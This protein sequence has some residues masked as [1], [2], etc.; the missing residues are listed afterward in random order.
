MTMEVNEMFTYVKLKNFMSFKEVYFNF[1]NGKR[2]PKKFVSIYGE[3][4]SGKSNFVQ[5]IDF[6]IKST[7]SFGMMGESGELREMMSL[8]K[9]PEQLIKLLMERMS[10]Q[11]MA[12]LCRMAE[13]ED[14]AC[15]EYG[16]SFNG[17]EGYYTIHFADRF[18]YER[19][20]YFTGKQRGII[21]EIVLKDGKISY[22]FSK[23]LFGNKKVEMEMIDEITKYWGKHTFLSILRKERKEKNEQ[24]MEENYLSY[25]F[26][27]LDM[28][29]EIT[30]HHKKNSLGGVE[31]AAKKPVNILQNLETGRVERSR[32]YI[33]DCSE[34]IIREFFT[35]TYADIKDVYYEKKYEE[36]EVTYKLF[37]KKMIGGKIR[38][39]D[40]LHESAGTQQIL[41]IIR[42]LLGAFCG[43]TV[44]YDEIDDGIHD[45]LLKIILE[46]M[47]DDITGQ[48]I[49]TTHNTY[50]LESIDIKSVYVIHVD[51]QGNKEVRCLDQYPRIQSS[52]NP[53]NMYLRGL[54]GGV[55]FV[56]VIDYD[57]II[58]ELES[59][60]E[61]GQ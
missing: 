46:S 58:Q 55:P 50:L 20:Y 61:G 21:F 47:L 34:R 22:H 32:E 27:I 1:E 38:T 37:V 48:L 26:D 19:L 11:N 31:I 40:F 51:Y 39:I 57:M 43:V 41:E 45:L 2:G 60:V 25:V 36:Q 18:T 42:A 30:V 24:Y 15:I 29:Q 52:N 8:G 17:H 54:F 14:E 12:E 53:R 10:I 4:G 44:V 3:N 23:K 33:L 56:D 7:L 49:I 35:Q 13:C 5:S 9:V 59:D 28:L 16:F 6:L